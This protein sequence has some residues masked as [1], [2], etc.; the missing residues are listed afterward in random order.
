MTIL[1][2]KETGMP[3]KLKLMIEINLTE[4]DEDNI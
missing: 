2:D 3:I 1:K 4:D